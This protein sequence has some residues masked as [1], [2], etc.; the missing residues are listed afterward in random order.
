MKA[1]P[2][3]RRKAEELHAVLAGTKPWAALEWDSLAV[4]ESMEPGSVDLVLGSPPYEKQRK[5]AEVGFDLEGQRWVDWMVPFVRAA[6][7]VS[8]G[9]AVFV[10]GHGRTEGFEWSGVPALLM[11]DLIRAGVSLRCPLIYARDGIF[12]SGGPDYFRYNYEFVLVAQS[13]PKRLPWC[14]NCAGGVPPRYG[15]GGD[16][17][18]RRADDSRERQRYNPPAITNPGCVKEE[19][20]TAGEVEQILRGAEA[21]CLER[22]VVGGNHMGHRLAHE[23]EAPY[24]LTLAERYVLSFCPPGGVVFDPFMGS[25]STLHAAVENRRRAV[26]CDLRRS[27]VDITRR[28][29]G[30]I[31]PNLMV[32]CDDEYEFRMAAKKGKKS[33]PK[34][35]PPQGEA[36]GVRDSVAGDA[37]GDRPGLAP[38]GAGEAAPEPA[39]PRPRAGQRG[40]AKAGPQDEG[41]DGG[42]VPPHHGGR[43]RRK[44]RG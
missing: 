13:S 18:F 2:N 1:D 40:A 21:S 38:G 6:A 35:D 39:R 23:N 25:G 29:L 20:Y 5:Y 26:G 43:Q 36:P 19:T 42:R 32:P 37:A 10:I 4:M 41:Q 34:D 8:R 33:G 44:G 9:L 17:C 24:P 30:E 7:R 12:G 28:R 14:N 31:T 11:A 15:R 22:H 27:Q 16:A 3:E